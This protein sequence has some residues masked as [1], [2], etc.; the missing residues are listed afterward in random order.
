MG[1]VEC[2][3]DQRRLLTEQEWKE[4]KQAST[5]REDFA[6]PCVICK[7]E[8]RLEDQVLLSCSHVFH[9]VQI[10]LKL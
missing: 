9:R 1:L 3:E 2:T 5:T 8:F 10:V 7:D 6:N 4:L